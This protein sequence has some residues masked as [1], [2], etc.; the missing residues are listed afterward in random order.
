MTG[1]WGSSL[2]HSTLLKGDVSDQGGAGGCS[3]PQDKAPL[4]ISHAA[5]CTP[6]A[7]V[8]Y[9]PACGGG[10]GILMELGE[11]LP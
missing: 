7:S 1:L 6:S 9:H 2:H 8:V 10:K 4:N 5:F 11:W 3:S